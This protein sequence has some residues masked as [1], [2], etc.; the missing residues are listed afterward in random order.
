MTLVKNRAKSR[1]SLLANT[2]WLFGDKM[3]RMVFGLAVS[4]IMARV[5]GPE[6][7]GKWNYAESFFRD[8]SDFHD[9]WL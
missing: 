4:I 6:E 2:S 3:I 9:S 8:V 5:L 7:L 1:R